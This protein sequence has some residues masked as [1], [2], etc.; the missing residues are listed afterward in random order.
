MDWTSLLTSHSFTFDPVTVALGYLI[1]RM[2][3]EIV[4]IKIGMARSETKIDFLA[5]QSG[6]QHESNVLK[7]DHLI[8]A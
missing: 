5:E 4:K 7:L 6:Q 1:F 8:K 2:N 3:G